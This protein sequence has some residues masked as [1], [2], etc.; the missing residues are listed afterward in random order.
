MVFYAPNT[1]W[2][3]IARLDVF[4][5]SIGDFSGSLW[6]IA[7]GVNYQVFKHF[8][9]AANYRFVKHGA[10]FDSRDWKGEVDI[11]FNGPSIGI[12]ANF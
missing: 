1:K 2:A 12:T 8:G 11:L 3:F 9:I 4:A 5:I 7:P 10:K 6:D